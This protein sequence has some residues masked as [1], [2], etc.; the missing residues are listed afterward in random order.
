MEEEQPGHHLGSHLRHEHAPEHSQRRP[1]GLRTNSRTPDGPRI[2]PDPAESS[3]A[4]AT[5][6]LNDLLMN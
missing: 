2:A 4:A 1:S 5:P 6:E 3:S